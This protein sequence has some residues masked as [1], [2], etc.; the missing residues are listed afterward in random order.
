[1][2][3]RYWLALPPLLVVWTAAAAQQH[4]AWTVDDLLMQESAGAFA[5]SPDHQLLVWTRTQVD[6]ESGKRAAN[7]TAPLLR[8]VGSFSGDAVG[9]PPVYD[10]GGSVAE[11]TVNEAGTGIPSGASADRPRGR[12]ARDN[13]AAPAY[14]GLRVVL[15]R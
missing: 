10:L 13:P 4:T 12:R 6:R 3:H 7:G 2:K 9:E 14:R 1:M 15:D 8:E 5:F 11:W